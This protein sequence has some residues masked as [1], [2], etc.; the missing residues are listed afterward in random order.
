MNTD[1]KCSIIEA[2]SN[3]LL[4]QME[5]HNGQIPA[6][7]VKKHDGPIPFIHIQRSTNVC[8]AVNCLRYGRLTIVAGSVALI[9]G[10]ERF[11]LDR[12][13]ICHR[14]VQLRSWTGNLCQLLS[15][16]GGLPNYTLWGRAQ[17]DHLALPTSYASPP[18]AVHRTS[19]HRSQRVPHALTAHCAPNSMISRNSA[20]VFILFLLFPRVPWVMVRVLFCFHLFT[21]DSFQQVHNLENATLVQA[22]GRSYHLNV[23]KSL[24]TTLLSVSRC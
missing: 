4:Y 12:D 24:L 10:C 5:V 14:S 3:E 11:S 17:H 2:S 9:Q 7:I 13:Q 23:A 6:Y 21:S 1:V 15:H 16:L 8:A 18:S 19:T 22:S 20:F